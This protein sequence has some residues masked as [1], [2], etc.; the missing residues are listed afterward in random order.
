MPDFS[1][2]HGAIRAALAVALLAAALPASAAAQGLDRIDLPAGW[3]PEGVATDGTSLY[4]GSLADGAIWRGD[5]TTGEGAVF[6]PGAEGTV[7]VGLEY[8]AAAGRLWVAGGPTGQVR[9]YDAATG[10]LLATYEFEA[11]FINDLAATE[12]GVFATDSGNPNLLEIPFGD[13]GGLPEPGATRVIEYRGQYEHQ[14]GFNANGIVAAPGWLI[15][16]Q[17]GTGRLF[18]VDPASGRTFLID[19]GDI[20]LTNGDGLLL[21]GDRL[22]VVRNQ[23]NTVTVLELAP[24]LAAASLV[25][26][27]TS[28]ELDVP[29]TVALTPDGLWAANARFGTTAE[30]DTEYW[31]TRLDVPPT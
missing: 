8:E 11:G 28:S 27:I 18:R 15:I 26:E 2:V 17:S 29:A 31:L 22:Y 21:D 16:V 4:V 9:A 10:E 14:E 20:A 19:S 1:H 5:P 30:P 13:D 3:Q 25:E 12:H 23:V 7:A 6:V 24:W